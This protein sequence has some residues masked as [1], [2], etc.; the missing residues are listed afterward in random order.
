MSL[1][2]LVYRIISIILSG[3]HI[4]I[5]SKIVTLNFLLAEII[6]RIKEY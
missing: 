4:L 6:D 1:D 2:T 5:T 3:T